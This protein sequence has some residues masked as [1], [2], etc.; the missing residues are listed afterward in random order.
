MIPDMDVL[1]ADQ[2]RRVYELTDGLKLNRDWVV[3]PLRGSETGFEMLLPDGKLLVRP[4]AGARFE[5]WFAGLSDRLRALPLNR[6]LRDSQLE[7]YYPRTP[8]G[9]APGSGARKYVK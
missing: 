4:A 3:V 8:A 1:T 9:A 5:A 6:P 7:R 2:V